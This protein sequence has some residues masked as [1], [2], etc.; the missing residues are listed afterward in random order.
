MKTHT[1]QNQKQLY[2]KIDALT[3]NHKPANHHQDDTNPLFEL[4][5][6]SHLVDAKK[7]QW[8]SA[9]RKH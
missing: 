6:S 5:E 9:P 2:K 8:E 1:D 3:K 7:N 4:A